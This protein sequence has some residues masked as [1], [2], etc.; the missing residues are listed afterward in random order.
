MMVTRAL[1]LA[2]LVLPALAAIPAPAPQSPFGEVTLT[3]T[4]SKY[5]GT[6]PVRIH[7]AGK[8]GVT[9]HPMVFNYVFER[10]DGAKSELKMIHVT[11][12]NAHVIGVGEDWRVGAA[13]QHLQLWMKLRVAS[14]NTRI[15]SNQ[16]DVEITCR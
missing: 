10:S 16:A 13:G 14:G 4:P 15:E 11:N 7:F 6:C 12:P 2:L 9:A 5:E 3:A 1:G 8:V